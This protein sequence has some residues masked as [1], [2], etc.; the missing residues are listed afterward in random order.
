M[1]S[2]DLDIQSSDDDGETELEPA[3]IY[4]LH[5]MEEIDNCAQEQG[6]EPGEDTTK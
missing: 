2:A 3:E 1:P 4:D 6:W 5:I